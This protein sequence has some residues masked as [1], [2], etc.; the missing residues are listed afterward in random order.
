MIVRYITG[1]D[2]PAYRR[3]GWRVTYYGIR[4]DDL[5]CFIASFRCC[6]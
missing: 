2:V 5:D 4:G 6:Q 1:I 3:C